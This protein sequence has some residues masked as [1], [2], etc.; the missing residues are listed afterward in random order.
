MGLDAPVAC[1]PL[2]RPKIRFGGF[3]GEFAP[4]A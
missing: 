2:H 3:S 1:Q 4:F